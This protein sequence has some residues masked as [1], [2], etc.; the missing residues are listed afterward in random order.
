[1]RHEGGVQPCPVVLHHDADRGA[2]QRRGDLDCSSAVDDGVVDQVAQDQVELLKARVNLNLRAG[3]E[4]DLAASSGQRVCGPS[5]GPLHRR[6]EIGAGC[7]GAWLIVGGSFELEQ[8]VGQAH[9]AGGVLSDVAQGLFQLGGG[10]ATIGRQAQQ[11][12]QQIETGSRSVARGAASSAAT[13]LPPALTQPGL[14]IDATF[15]GAIS[16]L[17]FQRDF[18]KD[19]L[20]TGRRVDVR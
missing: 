9:Q 8:L 17:S 13:L 15:N 1:M 12:A 14:L 5:G 2:A 7:G 4:M 6:G 3:A 10:A 11:G 20:A 19:L 18:W 16:A